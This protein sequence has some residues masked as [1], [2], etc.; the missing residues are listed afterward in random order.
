MGLFVRMVATLQAKF[1]IENIYSVHKVSMGRTQCAL[2]K[3]IPGISQE[4][5]FQIK[6]CFHQYECI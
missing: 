3:N 1:W 2:S 6:S 5:G 4:Y